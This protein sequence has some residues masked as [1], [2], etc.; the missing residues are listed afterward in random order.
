MTSTSI[1]IIE[2]LHRSRRPEWTSDGALDLASALN[3]ATADD[4]RVALVS[5]TWGMLSLARAIAKN[6]TTKGNS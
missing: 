5:F 3:T 6:Q 1:K 2:L 4:C